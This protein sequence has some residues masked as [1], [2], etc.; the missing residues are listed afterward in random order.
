M[1]V[2]DIRKLL[3]A[4]LLSGRQAAQLVLRDSV[5]EDHGRPRILSDADISAIRKGLTNPQDIKDY[6]AWIETYRILYPATT[7]GIG[8][9]RLATSSMWQTMA[10]LSPI[11]TIIQL[12]RVFA[13]GGPIPKL[14]TQAQ[15]DKIKEDSAK[16]RREGY[17]MPVWEVCDVLDG[18]NDLAKFVGLLVEDSIP[19]SRKLTRKEKAFLKTL[20][21]D[22]WD[23]KQWDWLDGLGVEVSTRDV[24]DRGI[25]MDWLDNGGGYAIV[26]DPTFLDVDE[27]GNYSGILSNFDRMIKE[28]ILTLSP[29]LSLLEDLREQKTS[30]VADV[31]NRDIKDSLEGFLGL[32]E[33]IQMASDM[34]EVDLGEDL[35]KAWDDVEGV[36]TLYNHLVDSIKVYEDL[37]KIYEDLRGHLEQWGQASPN[38]SSIGAI[39]HGMDRIEVDKLKPCAR[40]RRDIQEQI[41]LGLGRGWWKAIKSV[42]KDEA[43]GLGEDDA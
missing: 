35:R 15:F 20:P 9:A 30:I 28:Q 13:P 1:S 10:M 21:P 34:I 37:I 27:E 16:D 17:T 8:L 24:E 22:E 32:Q 40:S 19:L 38:L 11:L 33:A 26:Q 25:P 43:E 36:I 5:E 3:K 2:K 42:E 7:G 29:F 23:Q 39:A 4:G 12:H 6:N 14:V 18:G 31:W 41:A